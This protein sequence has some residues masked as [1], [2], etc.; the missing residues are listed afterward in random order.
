MVNF[1][2]GRIDV[3][4]EIILFIFG[5]VVK[6]LEFLVQVI[7]LG[8]QFVDFFLYFCFCIFRCVFEIVFQFFDFFVYFFMGMV[9]FG[10]Y[11]FFVRLEVVCE[12]ICGV[13]Y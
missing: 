12:V 4:F 9:N 8:F 11:F 5:D 13:F 3:C 2:K 6:V 1:F 10:F 7:V